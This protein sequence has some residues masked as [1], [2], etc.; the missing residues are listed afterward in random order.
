MLKLVRL[1]DKVTGYIF[2]PSS[3]GGSST[4]TPNTDALFS[5]AMGALPPDLGSIA[6]VQ[7]RWVDHRQDWDEWEREEWKKEGEERRRLKVEQEKNQVQEKVSEL[8]EEV[9]E[10]DAVPVTTGRSGEPRSFKV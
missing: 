6:D 2:I 5:S 1:I 8:T 9:A 3:S 4:T 7:E 10:D